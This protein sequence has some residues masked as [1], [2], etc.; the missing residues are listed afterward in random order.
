MQLKDLA[1]FCDSALCGFNWQL[2]GRA[3]WL[4]NKI[5]ILFFPQ[6]ELS[7]GGIWSPLRFLFFCAINKNIA[8]ILEKNQY[9]LLFA[10]INIP[11]KYIKHLF[12]FLSLGRYVFIYIFFVKKNRNKRL[13]IGLRKSYSVYKIGDSF[14]AFLL[15]F[16]FTS[17]GGDQRFFFRYC[18]I[19][20]DTSDKFDTFL[21]PLS[22]LQQKML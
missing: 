6:I 15:I 7:F 10:I 11:Q 18:D 8:T 2:R 19:M 9:F 22:F 5:G 14:M 16:F 21:G 17:N 1:P 20:V 3:M 4:P 12:F 13:L